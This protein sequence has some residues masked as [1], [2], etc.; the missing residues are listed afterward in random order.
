M[1]ELY[2][3]DMSS[4]AQKVRFVLEE[5]GLKWT[6]HELD[7][8]RGDQFDPKFLKINP[9][10]LVPVLVHD[11][12]PISESNIITEY[13]EE[14]FPERPLMPADPLGRAQVRAW[15]KPLDEGLH[16]HTIA[17]S[18]GLAFRHQLLAVHKTTEALDQHF[19]HIPDLDIRDI[20]RDVVVNGVASARVARAIRRFDQL[21]S[22]MDQA[23]QQGRWLVGDRL[24]LADIGYAPYATRL[25]HLHLMSLWDHRP[26][27]AAWYERLRDTVGY[28]E[29]ITRW[30][31]PG[32]LS[33]MGS[34][35]RDSL[36]ALQAHL[37]A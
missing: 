23:L 16:L 25:E 7:L 19:A 32:Y 14:A 15:T 3:N 1:L 10:G 5:K 22:H 18:F 21:V 37:A 34:S 2:H 28:R 4:C 24:T 20:E 12:V 9:R 8:R 6:S 13:I 17:L 35:G 33:E 31:N 36:P 29:G 11:G 26:R 30:F 27:F